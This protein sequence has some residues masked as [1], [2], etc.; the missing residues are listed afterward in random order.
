MNNASEQKGLSTTAALTRRRGFPV[1]TGLKAGAP[2]S[3]A[4]GSVHITAGNGGLAWS[5]CDPR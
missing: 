4:S 3:S 2:E 1:R 5:K